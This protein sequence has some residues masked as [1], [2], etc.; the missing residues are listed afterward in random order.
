MT[1]TLD[2]THP[3]SQRTAYFASDAMLR[4]NGELAYN[5][6]QEVD[7]YHYDIIDSTAAARVVSYAWA[8]QAMKDADFNHVCG[9]C[10]Y[11]TLSGRCARSSNSTAH[12][13]PI[14]K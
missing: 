13:S 14:S 2:P 7:T 1:G 6:T 5:T 3:S 9:Y 12:T 10:F 4:Q 11:K 8:T